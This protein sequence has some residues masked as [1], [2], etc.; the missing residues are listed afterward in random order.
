MRLRSIIIALLL[1]PVTLVALEFTRILIVREWL[2]LNGFHVTHDPDKVAVIA[3][4]KHDATECLR[5]RHIDSYIQLAPEITEDSDQWS[6][7]VKTAQIMKDALPCELLLPNEYGLGCIGKIWGPLIDENNCYWYENNSV[8]CFEG[9]KLVP[10]V[11]VCD[12][13]SQNLPDECL[14]RIAYKAKNV[15]LC[16]NITNLTL[17]SVCVVRINTWN[18]YPE[19]R[20]TQYFSMP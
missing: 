14:H 1:L 11:T 15:V 3:A 7:I 16:E 2:A 10:R 12:S 6:C 19:L 5:L 13:T 8:R 4:A 9:E 17:R 18:Q 20:S